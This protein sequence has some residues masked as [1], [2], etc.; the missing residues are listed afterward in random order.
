MLIP[1]VLGDTS[2][3]V[4]V[5]EEDILW[6]P[7]TDRRIDEVRHTHTHTHTYTPHTKT[8]KH[9]HTHTHTV[10]R[11]GVTHTQTHTNKQLPVLLDEGA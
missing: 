9:T 6:V 1:Y 11:A 10:V 8:Y 4:I 7:Q 3:P 2:L 5:T